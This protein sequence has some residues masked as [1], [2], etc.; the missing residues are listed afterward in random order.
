MNPIEQRLSRLEKRLNLYRIFFGVVIIVVCG[1]VLMSFDKRPSVPDVL[2]AKSFEVLD[3]NGNVIVS[4]AKDKEGGKVTTYSSQGK[5]LV[6]LITTDGGGGGINTFDD[7]GEVMFKVTKT[8]GGGGYIALF[9]KNVKEM[10]EMGATTDNSGYIRVNNK[11]GDKVD[12]MTATT[13]NKGYISVLSNNNED[14]V[15]SGS[16]A[17]GR[18][19]VS[20][21]SNRIIFLGAMD[22]RDGNL[23][24][25]NAYGSKSGS[26]PSY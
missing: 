4:I 19:N 11:N 23:T 1:A 22:N 24:I 12:W 13:E 2:Q 17:G 21:S 8:T 3:D 7:G 18:I 9:N 25:Y 16:D 6:S 10:I 26:L 5:K 20:N 15:L 14:V